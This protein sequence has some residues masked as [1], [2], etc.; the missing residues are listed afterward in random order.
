MSVSLQ[1]AQNELN[2]RNENLKIFIG[3]ASHELKTPIALIKAYAM[4]IQDGIDDGTY[5]DTIIEESEKMNDII[6]NLIYLSKYEKREVKINSFDLKEILLL[7]IDEYKL[8]INENNVEVN[9]N[10]DENE[11]MIEGDIEGIKIVL[12]NLISNSIKYTL[13]DKIY[14]SLIRKEKVY[15]Y[16]SNKANGIIES[17]LDNIW[18]P[19]YVLEKSRNRQLSGTGLGLGL[20][21]EILD[22]QKLTYGT[23]LKN[24]YIEFL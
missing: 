3:G 1:K 14:I 12:R 17:E 11:F 6:N 7:I 21:K 16:V 2:K 22:A 20:V 13:D 19:F 23:K 10:I 5:L 18:K 15:I 24:D 9:L 4:G 8:I